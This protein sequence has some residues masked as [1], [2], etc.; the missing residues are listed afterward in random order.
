MVFYINMKKLDLT[1]SQFEADQWKFII[2]S[3]FRN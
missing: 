1:S 3:I 2:Q